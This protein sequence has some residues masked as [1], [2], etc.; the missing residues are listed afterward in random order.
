MPPVNLG[1]V[2]LGWQR[3]A[4]RHRGVIRPRLFDRPRASRM[5][6]LLATADLTALALAILLAHLLR[7][8][9]EWF[10]RKWQVLLSNPGFVLWAALAGLALLAA[11]E[12]YEAHILLRRRETLV[13]LLLAVTAWTLALALGNYLHPPWTYGRGILA[14]TAGLWA[15]QLIAVRLMVARRLRS[16]RRRKALVVGA[17]QAVAHACRELGARDDAPWRPIDGASIAPRALRAEV[18]R[19]DAW[20]VVLAAGDEQTLAADLGALHFSG[21]PVVVASELWAWL[22]ER[23]P[24]ASLSPSL[25]LHQPG[26]SAFYSAR[27]G[28][29]TRIADILLASLLAVATAPLLLAAVLAVRLAGGGPALYRQTRVGQFGRSFVMLKLRTMTPDAE[30][31]GPAFAADD[32]PR[33]T[34]VGRVLRRFRIDE[35]PQLWNVLRGEMSLVGPRPERPEFAGRL[36]TEIPFYAFR[37]AVPPGITGWAQV[38]APYAADDLAHH[39][40][41]LEY[42]LYFIRERSLALYLLTLLRTVSTALVGS[43]RARTTA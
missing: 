41:K 22:D 29:L 10:V 39:R 38:N 32:D 12:L 25:F 40:L 34:R 37:S 24:L 13:R 7:F 9:P 6:A 28:R 16:R 19:Q 20:L 35:L 15:V 42:D 3:A 43:R 18:E 21:V 4:T 31:T 36:S 1:W 30:K 27:L 17:P 26:F 33:T 5:R 14:L 8:W 23:L 2:T 11:G